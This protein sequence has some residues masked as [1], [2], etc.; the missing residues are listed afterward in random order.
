MQP[1]RCFLIKHLILDDKSGVANRSSNINVKEKNDVADEYLIDYLRSIEVLLQD[2]LVFRLNEAL[3]YSCR[4]LIELSSLPSVSKMHLEDDFKHRSDIRETSARISDAP[5]AFNEELECHPSDIPEWLQYLLI[6]SCLLSPMYADLQL[7]SINT[8]LEMIDLLDSGIEQRKQQYSRISQSGVTSN[9]KSNENAESNHFV[10]V[11]Q[12]LI[13]ERA[14]KFIF[15]QTVAPQVIAAKLWDGLGAMRPVHHLACVKQLHRLHNTVPDASSIERIVARTLGN[16]VTQNF[17]PKFLNNVSIKNQHLHIGQN[18]VDAFQRFTLFWHLSRDQII[19]KSKS[20]DNSRTFDVCLLKMLDNL[21]MSSGPLKTLSQSWLIHAMARG[22]IARIMEPL[23][24]TLLDPTTARVSVLHCRIEHSSTVNT[25]DSSEK[26]SSDGELC[27]D[28]EATHKIYTISTSFDVIYH[29]SENFKTN[30]ES[31]KGLKNHLPLGSKKT[32]ILSKNDSDRAMHLYALNTINNERT[33]V[34]IKNWIPNSI[35]T[36]C[37][38][39]RERETEENFSHGEESDLVER[40]AADDFPQIPLLVNPFALVPPNVEEYESFTKG[41]CREPQLE[42]ATKDKNNLVTTKLCS[43]D[44]MSNHNTSKSYHESDSDSLSIS[45]NESSSNSSSDTTNQAISQSSLSEIDSNQLTNYVKSTRELEELEGFP[46]DMSTI[47][48]RRS[49]SALESFKANESRTI[50][51][52]ILDEVIINV[53]NDL[54]KRSFNYLAT[55]GGCVTGPSSFDNISLNDCSSCIS[56]NESGTMGTTPKN[57]MAVHPLH[58]HIL[59]YT[60]VSD[61]RQVLYSMQCVKNML[62]TNPR[63][64]ICTLSTTSLNSSRNSARSYQIQTL[65]ARHRKSVFGRNF[66]GDLVSESMATFRNSTLIEVLISTSL[67]YLR[68]YYPNMGK[69]HLREEDIQGNR[70]VQ[71]MSIDIL[72]VLVSELILVVRDNSQAYATY[73]SDL[74]SRCK[75]QKVVLHCLLAGVNDMKRGSNLVDPTMS[76]SNDQRDHPNIGFTEDILKFNEIN[77]LPE[78]GTFT[79]TCEKISNYSEAFQVQVLRLLLSLVMLEQIIAQQKIGVQGEAVSSIPNV[80]KPSAASYSRSAQPLVLRYLHDQAIPDQPMFLAAIISALRHDKMRHLHPHWTSLVNSCLPFLGKSLSITVVEVTSQLCRNLE[81]LAP[82]YGGNKI[83][84]TKL[85]ANVHCQYEKEMSETEQ[86][87]REEALKES[88]LG[89]IPADY[90]VTQLESLTVITHYCLLESTAQVNVSFPQ[91]G[92]ISTS[93]VPSGLNTGGANTQSGEILNNLLHVFISHNDAKNLV[94][95]SLK[96]ASSTDSLQTARKNLLSTLPRLVASCATLWSS[97]E[98]YLNNSTVES[99]MS[100]NSSTSAFLVGDPKTVRNKIL[101]LLSPIAHHHP[102]PF[103]SAVSVAWQERRTQNTLGMVR[104]PLPTCNGKQSV[105]VELVASIKTLPVAT[106]IQTVRQVLKTPPSITG[107]SGGSSG[108]GGKINVEVSVLQ[109]FYF[110]L[111][112]CSPSKIPDLWPSLATLLKDCLALAPSAIFLALAILDIYVHRSSQQRDSQKNVGSEGNNKIEISRKE[113]KEL[114]EIAGKLVDECSRIGGSCL[115]QT[116]WLR[117]NMA[118]RHDLQT[119]GDN[120]EDMDL[121]ETSTKL[122]GNFTAG[123]IPKFFF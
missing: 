97:L 68:S 77:S 32:Q 56:K 24:L 119:I 23:F 28:S 20:G 49:S 7:E 86:L 94:A 114:Q 31:E 26:I 98:P 101:D 46:S 64:A 120:Q 112:R 93:G 37:S 115:E 106:V 44:I 102:I 80:S 123:T 121:S 1:N 42:K 3:R 40:V 92:G 25:S 43:K 96:E 65:L 41:Y 69:V 84:Q 38:L 60:Q 59:L 83:A 95:S 18:T 113:S 4:I 47:S 99:R 58:S 53:V 91:P 6:C 87:E 55:S 22:D 48:K 29:V 74:F 54:S 51:S 19:K 14:Y 116:T 88:N 107:H 35:V 100:S 79:G 118:V 78:S 70:E 33:S 108:A 13:K 16:G 76:R 82:F 122:S 45:S 8:L 61:S 11:M 75:V 5:K 15:H 89:H 30:R 39:S 50:A 105:L 12:P 81:K 34:D 72:V 73:I 62:Q 117:R 10:I 109:F 27:T 104:R 36:N 103:L 9:T 17:N 2:S 71:L 111:A 57:T 63:L 21:N 85:D 67:Y 66:A 52:K 90:I 110:Y